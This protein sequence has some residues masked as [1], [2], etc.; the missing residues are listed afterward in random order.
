M[1]KSAAMEAM[2]AL[3]F[4]FFWAVL[5]AVGAAFYFLPTIIAAMQHRTNLAV[6]AIVNLLL[7]WSFVGWIVALVL[8]LMKESAPVQVVHVQQNVGYPFVN[9]PPPPQYRPPQPAPGSQITRAYEY[10]MDPAPPRE[11]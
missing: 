2:A 3:L 9:Q 10:P 8:A 5:F 7:G 11:Q 6:V 1:A 4:M